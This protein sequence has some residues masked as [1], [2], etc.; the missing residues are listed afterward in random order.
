MPFQITRPLFLFMGLLVLF[1]CARAIMVPKSFGEFGHYRGDSPAEE[2]RQKLRYTGAQA[3]RDCH[4]KELSV[5]DRGAH[6]SIS[7]ETC[8][9]PGGEHSAEPASQKLDMPDTRDFCALCHAANPAR[10]SE[11]PQIDLKTHWVKEWGSEK[12]ITC[13]APHDPAQ[14]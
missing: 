3:C 6:R 12:C 9:G 4:R 2:S 7:C 10:P 8:H 5:F 1:F 11:F 13:H 14:K